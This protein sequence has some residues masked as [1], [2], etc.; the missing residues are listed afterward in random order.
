[1]LGGR[2]ERDR[3]GTCIM[4]MDSS[5]GVPYFIF[6]LYPSYTTFKPVPLIISKSLPHF[7]LLRP[8]L[9][10]YGRFIYV[11]LFK[12]DSS[13]L[14]VGFI[15]LVLVTSLNRDTGFEFQLGHRILF[16]CLRNSS[17]F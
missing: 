13:N 16:Q 15:L 14:I 7:C 6:Y 10:I 5:I 1:M 12:Q 17:G 11:C 3:W 9:V 8:P 2:L 4:G